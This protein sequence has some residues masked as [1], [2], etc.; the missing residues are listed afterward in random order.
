MFSLLLLHLSAVSPKQ[1]QFPGRTNNLYFQEDPRVGRQAT[2][3]PHTIAPCPGDELWCEEAEDYPALVTLP[4]EVQ[5][6]EAIMRKIF[7]KHEDDPQLVFGDKSREKPRNSGPQD[8][9]P[10][11]IPRFDS[12]QSLDI[13]R[14]DYNSDSSLEQES[15]ACDHRKSTVYPKKARNV[16]G[17]FVF[18]VNDEQYRQAVEIEQCLDEGEE[19]RNQDD[20]PSFGSTV[21][22]QK[23]T[24]YKLYVINGEG[25]QVYDS[26]SLPAACLCHHK[27]DF[28]IRID[29]A[30]A[31]E[32]PVCPKAETLA[33]VTPIPEKQTAS[34]SASSTTKEPQKVHFQDIEMASPS[35]S[36]PVSSS[37]TTKPQTSSVKT[38]SRISFGR[39]KRQTVG[40]RGNS[41]YCEEKQDYPADRVLAALT[42]SP[43]LSQSLFA[44]LFDS[45]CKNQHSADGLRGFSLDEEQLC[46]GRTNIIFPKMAKN[47]RDE[48]KFVVNINN[49]TQS[50]EVEECHNDTLSQDIGRELYDTND[51]GVCLYS[52][53]SGDN[54][55]L[56]VCRQLY[57]EHKLLALTEKGQLEV[58]SFELPSACACFVRE[59]FL[60]FGFRD[61][62]AGEGDTEEDTGNTERPEV[63]LPRQVE[64]DTGAPLVFGAGR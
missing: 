56:T 23:Y 9:K 20:A 3:S 60:D 62:M 12:S 29:S 28:A 38:N 37:S 27:S 64:A 44:Q 26:F 46:F 40:C 42:Q 6:V 22:R 16:D 48:W 13:T 18:V 31:L 15:R 51:F 32:L 25:E 1:F 53:A 30:D 54:P 45:Q 11:D 59:D 5:S 47:L 35:P 55:D 19:C 2:D 58:D 49:Y 52:G 21:C 63:E 39:K 4:R 43:A 41:L 57:T 61:G 24:T 17:S 36:P 50:V 8:P 33:V 34:S 14:F 7:L 10:L